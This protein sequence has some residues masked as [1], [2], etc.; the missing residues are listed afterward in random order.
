M[1]ADMRQLAHEAEGIITAK[2]ADD[3]GSAVTV[4]RLGAA[5]ACFGLTTATRLAGLP[6][7]LAYN[8]ARG[9][10]LGDVNHLSAICAFF[11]DAGVSPLIEVWAGDASAA[12]GRRLAEAGFY[13]ADVNVTLRTEPGR[14]ASATTLDHPGI[15]LR[16]ITATDDDTV[17]LD[18]LFHGYGLHTE[19]GSV[20]QTMMAIEH[21]TRHLRRYLAYVDDQPAAAAAV[22]ITPEGAY[23]AGAATV[24]AMRNRGCQ[25]VLIRRRLHDAAATPHPVVVTTAF[26]SSSQANL[27]RH[28]FRIIHT[29]TL[30]RPLATE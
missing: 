10:T 13:A 26:G 19:P 22:Y 1:M 25:G 11:T 23:L 9:F 12:L 5:T 16:E 14:S 18:T 21:R 7:H 20:P 2:I 28:G 8:K 6:G 17:Y 27:Q 29:R 3:F 24:P 30:W 4:P 15:E